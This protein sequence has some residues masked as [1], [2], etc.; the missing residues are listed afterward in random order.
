MRV[1]IIYVRI[2]VFILL[3]IPQFVS[4]NNNYDKTL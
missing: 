3:K 2:V 4:Y 1:Y